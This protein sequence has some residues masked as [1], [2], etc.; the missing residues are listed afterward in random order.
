M[1][2]VKY[3]LRVTFFNTIFIENHKDIKE[4]IICTGALKHDSMLHVINP[5]QLKN[6]ES[7]EVID[8][9]YHVIVFEVLG[10]EILSVQSSLLSSINFVPK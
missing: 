3:L 6:E 9:S 2:A 1:Y 7:I 4:P 10:V 8:L 5:T